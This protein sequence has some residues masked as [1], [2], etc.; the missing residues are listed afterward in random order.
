MTKNYILLT[1]ILLSGILCFGQKDAL[2]LKDLVGRLK[3][4][5]RGPYKDIR[6]FCPDGT[7]VPA[8]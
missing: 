4:D 5:T 3:E 8:K 1:L 6:W 2:A 7:N